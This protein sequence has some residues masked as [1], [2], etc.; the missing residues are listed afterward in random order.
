MTTVERLI[1][2]ESNIET[3]REIS[4]FLLSQS[5]EL[6]RK[7]QSQKSVEAEAKDASQTWL[8]S[9]LEAHLH[10]LTRR[11]F[12]NGRETLK[13]RSRERRVDQKKQLLLHAKSLAGDA[14]ANERSSLP[15]E[16]RMHV[17]DVLE[18]LSLAQRS[19]PGLT[20]ANA[21]VREVP[22]F[23]ET[24]SEITVT[25]RVY[26][27]VVHHRQKYKVTNVLSKKE[28]IVTAPG[29]VKL[30][31]GSRYSVDFALSVVAGKFLNHLPYERQ[32]KDMS[33]LGLD[34]PV[35]TLSRLAEQVSVHCTDVVERIRLDIFRS[36]LAC[37]LDETRWP[38]LKKTESDGQMWVLSNQAGSYYRFEP[39]RSGAIADELLKGY[40]GAVL[41]DKFSGYLHFRNQETLNWGLC[42]S[43]ARREFFDLRAVYETEV[44]KIVGA[45]DD[46]FEI[47]RKAR[48][49][50]E[51][52][53][54][55]K[56]ESKP[57][58]AEIKSL[59]EDARA[60]FF[61]QD[62]FCKAANYVLSAWAE[63][64][65]FADDVRLPLSNNEAERALRH[66]VLGRKNFNGSKTINGADVAATLYSVIE[67]CK[68]VQ[69]DPVD[70][71]KYVI[72]ENEGGRHPLTP[73]NRARQL[74]GII[75]DISWKEAV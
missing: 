1:K 32:R 47:E 18:V 51:L 52:E 63:F 44:M 35:M 17:A 66:A 3:L 6:N 45:I 46:L 21:V 5:E 20:A 40:A 11:F 75:S 61:D 57:K 8:N 9:K 62:D 33:R 30:L 54:L 39:A 55:R 64:T 74:R 72:Y 71:M 49:W 59:L 67:S 31:P 19:D 56:N 38:I 65:A 42:W 53:A 60:E 23:T 15:V 58:L 68:K 13:N 69:L 22:D 25:E 43:H 48:T 16:M 10:K 70:Y 28:T 29:P 12:E 37:H 34:V 27:R 4:L 2:H 7:L 26:T 36:R 73:L 24:S 14:P 50:P 41:T